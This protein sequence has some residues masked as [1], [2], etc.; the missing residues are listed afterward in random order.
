VL[1]ATYESGLY[2]IINQMERAGVAMH[3][4]GADSLTITEGGYQ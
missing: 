1:G 2:R 3:G 4:S